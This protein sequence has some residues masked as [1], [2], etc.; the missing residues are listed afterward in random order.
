MVYRFPS[1]RDPD[2]Q[3]GE[4]LIAS[5]NNSR[6]GL[7]DLVAK[8]Q[9]LGAQAI[10]SAFPDV[11]IGEI[12]GA[13]SPGTPPRQT[14]D[15]LEGLL[16]GYRANGVPP[17]LIAAAK[18]R[19]LGGR[20]YRQASISGA[21]FT[22]A[23][24]LANGESSPDDGYA[25]LRAVTAAD[26]DRVLNTYFDPQRRLSI[27][28]SP[29]RVT[30][31]PKIDP[32]AGVEN[33]AYTADREEA[34]PAWATAYFSAPLRAPNDENVRIYRLANG[35][36]MTVR[37][38]TLSPTVVVAGAI[39]TAPD[40]NEPRGKDGVALLTSSL[41]PWGTTTMDRTA[42]VA[43]LDNIQ[44][45]VDL[46]S[47]F[48]MSAQSKDFDAAVALLADALL[49]PAFPQAQFDIFKNNNAAAL[50]AVESQPSTQAALAQTN[51]LY[52]PGDP[53]RRRETSA[54]VAGL[55]LADVKRWY[56]RA[57]RPDETAIAI[58]G[59][60]TPKQAQDV[61]AKYFGGWKAVGP[62]PNFAY[63]IVKASKSQTVTVTSSVSKQ[64]QVTLTQVLDLHRYDRDAIALELAN[65]ILSGEG[66]GSMLFRDVRTAHGYAYGIDSSMDVG[67]SSST[68]SVDF[69]A[70]PKNV[71]A[72]QAQ[73]IAVIRRLQSAPLPLADVQRAKALLLAQRVLPLDSYAGVAGDLLSDA[74][75]LYTNRD[76]NLYW[77]RLLGV[78]PL[79][80]QR[81][82]RKYIDTKRFLRVIVAPGS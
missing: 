41:L 26:V 18:A 22:W 75:V 11:G 27:L 82:M 49:H 33:V 43:A 13:G 21:A 68:F 54:T 72:A 17:D 29:K 63:P 31:I 12:V 74:Q 65:T 59:D 38:E 37:R 46:G 23:N 61:V 5:L 76:A 66:T 4:V 53:R 1:L 24:A 15:A 55:T 8:G 57:Y 62:Q 42:Y 51:A 32:K 64:T 77:R 52:P 40:L 48:S 25:A 60:V 14:L 30:S 50:A 58:V 71:E 34:I 47:D 7:V 10:S 69:S 35:L 56:A 36:R 3:A 81:A 78:T 2:Y 70:A 79:E 39:R 73:A 19:L 80:L 16:D 6:G 9:I 44:A 67:T 20:A 28:L 45:S